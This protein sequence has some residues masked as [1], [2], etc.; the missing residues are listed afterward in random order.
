M[1]EKKK[2]AEVIIENEEEAAELPESFGER[3]RQNKKKKATANTKTLAI[4]IGVVVVLAAALLVLIFF[5][6]EEKKGEITGPAS[7]SA[8]VDDDKVWEADV[9][10]NKDGKIKE[11]GSGSLLEL[12][13]ADI[14]KIKL[15]NDK[16]TL[17]FKSYTP[18]V[19]LDETD[20]ETGKKKT[21][22]DATQYTLVGFEDLEIRGDQAGLL[23]NLCS[24][25]S[26]NSVSCEDA[27]DKLSDFGMDK[28]RAVATVTFNDNTKAI[29]KLGAD[30]PQNL[31]SYVMFGSGKAV[32][33]CDKE[34]TEVLLFG[35][36][37]LM[38]LNINSAASDTDNNTLKSASISGSNFSDTIVLEP[39]TDDAVNADY[40]LTA[41]NSSLADNTEASNISGGIRGLYAT[42]VKAVNPSSAQ[43]SKL[44]LSTPYAE[45]K[46]EYP[47]CTVDII[48]AKP[49]SSGNV[50]IMEKD[51]KLVYSISAEKVAW[52]NT[53]YEKLLPDYVF[54][55]QL[56]YVSS[57]EVDGYKFT[58]TTEEKNVADEN[59]DVSTTKETNT[60]YNGKALD[61][62]N[63]ETFFYN[64]TLLKKRDK[65]VSSPSG[66]ADLTVTYSYS[67]GRAD[68][69][70]KFYKTGDNHTVTINGVTSGT[71]NSTYVTKLKAQAKSVSKDDNVKS[72]W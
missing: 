67:N 7:V 21:G 47:D 30:A 60:S 8:K 20:P 3:K 62:G 19:E 12:V 34:S 40:V 45:I 17:T 9:K 70:L 10:T 37:D 36:T 4:I 64:L 31:G 57:V 66:S 32:Y 14:K 44:G 16:G 63:F 43:L 25:L 49:D 23:A 13:P 50:L 24:T 65:L 56:A 68:D 46:A 27:T 11:N 6:R 2:T 39:C 53:S 15:E 5:P 26:F 1:D 52:V 69:V 33:L 48:A 51:G 72:F 18:I 55:A 59:G 61:E 71:V 38:D 35:I 58:V 22:T 29:I 41:P 54:E 42:S 28:P